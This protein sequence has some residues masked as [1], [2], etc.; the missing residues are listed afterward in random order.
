MTD[1]GYAWES[2]DRQGTP[3]VDKYLSFHLQ[4]TNAILLLIWSYIYGQKILNIQMKTQRWHQ[5]FFLPTVISFHVLC[6][7]YLL[8]MQA[9]V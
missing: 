1:L 6:V 2:E 4:S 5:L 7:E 3:G 8:F 9:V